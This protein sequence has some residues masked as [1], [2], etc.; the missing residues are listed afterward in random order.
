SV[1]VSVVDQ[2]HAA[3]GHDERTTA[4]ERRTPVIRV[5]VADLVLHDV[6]AAAAGSAVAA[7][8]DALVP[9]V[10]AGVGVHVGGHGLLADEDEV[11][12]A[13]GGRDHRHRYLEGPISLEGDAVLGVVG[14]RAVDARRVATTGGV[15][16]VATSRT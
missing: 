14:V 12:G 8:V 11:A 4:R 1:G 9:V 13:D 7:R 10:A 6:G 16:R 2:A 5:I 15:G 3:V